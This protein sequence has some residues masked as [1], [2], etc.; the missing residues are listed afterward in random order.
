MNDKI[1]QLISLSI[2]FNALVDKGE[3]LEI[4]YL[5]NALNNKELF[6]LLKGLANKLM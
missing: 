4:T 2:D 3:T 5:Y 1:V 6:K